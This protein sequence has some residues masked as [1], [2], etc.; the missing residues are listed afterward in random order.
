MKT[1]QNLVVLLILCISFQSC[2][3]SDCEKNIS[4]TDKLEFEI[5][6]EMIDY[7]DKQIDKGILYGEASKTVQLGNN[8]NLTLVCATWLAESPDKSCGRQIQ[9]HTK[10][11]SLKEIKNNLSKSDSLK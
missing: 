5:I 2:T 8:E 1:I 10:N 11:V 7:A 3:H 4:N 9:I 6:D